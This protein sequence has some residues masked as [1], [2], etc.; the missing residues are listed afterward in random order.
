MTDSVKGAGILDYLPLAGGVFGA[1]GSIGSSLIQAN[2]VRQA[3]AAQERALGRAQGTIKGAYETAQGY[4]QPYQQ[5]GQQDYQTMR[6]MMGAGQF[7]AD[8]YSYQPEQFQFK[9]D[10]GYQ[11]RLQEGNRQIMGQAAARGTQ[12]SG[13]T[14]K[15][16]QRYGQNFAS[17]EV[18][19][20]FNRF[21]Q[22]RQFGAENAWNQY[23]A[24]NQQAQNR[25]GQM[26]TM[27]GYGVNAANTMGEQA[28]GYGTNMA[29]LYGAQGNVQAAGAMGRGQAYGNMVNNFGNFAPQLLTDFGSAWAA[30]AP[31]REEKKAKANNV[32]GVLNAKH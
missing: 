8:P 2:S 6:Q 23:Q 11:A 30:G 32:W 7:N 10:P 13:A 1:L 29:G 22:N 16:L 21:T 14:Q 12:L 27:T 4:Q 25:F 20:A 3:Q 31:A 9:A 5:G 24:Q 15:A 18:G 28:T 26:Q 17:Q 19:N